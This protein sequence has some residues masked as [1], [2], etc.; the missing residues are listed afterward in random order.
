MQLFSEEIRCTAR[1]RYGRIRKSTYKRNQSHAKYGRKLLLSGAD[2]NN[3]SSE[4]W[5]NQNSARRAGHKNERESFGAAAAR[6]VNQRRQKR[7]KSWCS[8]LRQEKRPRA[9]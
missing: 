9:Y 8:F 7:R 5:P 2:H 3:N 6:A 4:Y 1:R